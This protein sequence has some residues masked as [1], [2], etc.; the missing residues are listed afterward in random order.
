MVQF[1]GIQVVYRDDFVELKFSP[2]RKRRGGKRKIKL[3][4]ERHLFKIMPVEF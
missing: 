4:G 2:G 3:C 1:N